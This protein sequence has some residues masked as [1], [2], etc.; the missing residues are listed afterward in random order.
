MTEVT[1]ASDNKKNQLLYNQILP[2]KHKLNWF[3]IM[4]VFSKVVT[5][6]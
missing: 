5:I 6:F 2:Y 4:K 1:N 3:K